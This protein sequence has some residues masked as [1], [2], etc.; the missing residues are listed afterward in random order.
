MVN[1]KVGSWRFVT[2]RAIRSVHIPVAFAPCEAGGIYPF[3]NPATNRTTGAENNIKVLPPSFGEQ[4]WCPW[5]IT[6]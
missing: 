1:L 2:E 6:G 4:L 5:P 3:A